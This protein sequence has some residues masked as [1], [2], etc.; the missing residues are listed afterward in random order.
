M[1]NELCNFDGLTVLLVKC[2][3][4]GD[5]GDISGVKSTVLIT[6]NEM[7]NLL[8]ASQVTKYQHVH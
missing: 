2:L 4:C 7:F 1:I 5:N 3:I 8:T 6:K